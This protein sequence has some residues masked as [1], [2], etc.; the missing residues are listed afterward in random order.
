MNR[1]QKRIL[2]F[3]VGIS[4]LV[5]VLSGCGNTSQLSQTEA[6]VNKFHMGLVSWVG[7]GPLYLAQEKGFIK[8][9]GIELEL[10]TFEDVSQRRVAMIK[11][12]LDGYVDTVDSMIIARD[13]GV[14]GTA[15]MQI[16]VSN[17]ADA[18]IATADI[19]SISDLKGKKIA[20]Q[21]NF[22]P[23]S[24]LNFL[25]IQNG[26]KPDDVEIIDADGGSAGAAFVSG[27]VDVAVTFEPWVSQAKEREGGHVLASSADVYGA[28]VD[29]LLIQ[30]KYLT[31]H[32]EV[33]QGIMNAWFE[34]LAYIE[35]NPEES[36]E[37]MA[38][39]Y[40][41]PADEFMAI[42][43]DGVEWPSYEK[44]VEYFASDKNSSVYEVI[45]TF[46]NVLIETD[47]ISPNVN[48]EGLIDARLL[49]NLYDK[50]YC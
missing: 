2:G 42:I 38:K 50:L 26:M 31:E 46:R 28:I 7:Y 45:D 40:G 43:A 24:L 30:E 33:V 35:K 8:K 22:V 41:M 29:V 10:S 9:Q 12:D 37:I 49:E 44:N 18:I 48:L 20:A 6:E 34:A 4:S 16:D 23:E 14:P 3:V 19:Q 17:G 39:H 47:T 25:L 1:I 32:P 15:V 36:Y 13:Q 27:N 21:K 5:L 11:G